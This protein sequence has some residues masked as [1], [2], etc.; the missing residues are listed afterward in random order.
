[1][2]SPASTVVLLRQEP[3]GIAVYL[4]RRH[5]G[6]PF[7]GG[8]HVFPGGRVEESDCDRDYVTVADGI[9]PAVSRLPGVEESLAVGVC[10]AAV[11]ET[12]EE[13]GILL[14]RDAAGEFV[15][16]TGMDDLR[17]KLAT[18]EIRLL[19]VLRLHQWRL[20]VDALEYFAHWVTPPIETRRFDTRFFLAAVPSRQVAVHDDR[21]A[22]DGVWIPP[23]AAIVRC[24]NGDIALPPPTWTTLRW[25]ERFTRIEDALEW[26]R[27]KPVPRIEPGFI[28]DGDTR[29]V[30]L[31]GDSEMPPVEGFE[32]R[33]T[34]FLL[35]AGRWTPSR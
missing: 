11:R 1:M 22:T 8:A 6:I 21:E 14:A 25:L 33:E 35:S 26:A 31:P 10:I 15:A 3:D 12:F 4:T 34:R 19:D 30:L 16:P 24:R 27:S 7:M 9:G 32:P 28:Q 29:I 18:G 2:P 20:A 23:A 17:L 13:A 5:A